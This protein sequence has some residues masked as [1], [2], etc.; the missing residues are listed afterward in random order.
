MTS[1]RLNSDIIDEETGKVLEIDCYRCDLEKPTFRKVVGS[2]VTPG[3]D[4]T[5]AYKL[6]CGH[7]II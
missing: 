4:P 3:P 2:F 6:E 7:S 5:Q 1:Y